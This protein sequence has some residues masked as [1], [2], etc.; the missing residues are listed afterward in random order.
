MLPQRTPTHKRA[1][2]ARGKRHQETTTMA[3]T[4]ATASN[5]TSYRFAAQPSGSVD[6]GKSTRWGSEN[7]GGNNAG[8]LPQQQGHKTTDTTYTPPSYIHGFVFGFRQANMLLRDFLQLRPPAVYIETLR[9]WSGMFFGP[10]LAPCCVMAHAAVNVLSLSSNGFLVVHP[11]PISHSG[12]CGC[13]RPQLSAL[14]VP[15]SSSSVV[16]AAHRSSSE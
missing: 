11:G 4:T 6:L 16:W 8:E 12:A 5:R 7:A 10:A 15:P 13:H 2:P 9:G 14:L 3:A 1:A